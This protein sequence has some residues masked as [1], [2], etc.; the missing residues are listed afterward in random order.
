MKPRIYETPL[1]KF[2]RAIYP[3]GNSSGFA[4]IG[5]FVLVLYDKA[6]E[7]TA[8]GIFL[9]DSTK[10][11]NSEASEA[12]IIIAL[13]DDA[14]KWNYDRTRPFNGNRPDLGDRIYFERYAGT[15]LHG[16]DGVKY[17]L[18]QDRC[19]AAVSNEAE[20]EETAEAA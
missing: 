20:A 15:V 11:N 5:E 1:G 7:K 14:F 18:M 19:V 8:G 12:G 17:R 6:P 3:G 4:P 9:T 2:E 10:E 16:E 13:G